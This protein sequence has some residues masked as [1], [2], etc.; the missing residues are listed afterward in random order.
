[1]SDVN[2]VIMTGRLTRDCELRYTPHGTAVNEFA[3]AS[4]RFYRSKGD[5]GTK[6]D[7]VFMD[8]TLWGRAGETLAEF[9]SKGQLVSVEGRVAVDTWKDKEDN[10]TRKKVYIHCNA[11]NLLGP[12]VGESEDSELVAASSDKDVEF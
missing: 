2:T 7:T 8:C 10:K 9:L 6:K 11:V 1:M 12:R 4:N 5:D 3:I